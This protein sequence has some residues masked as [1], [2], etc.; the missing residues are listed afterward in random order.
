[1]K[2]ILSA[3]FISLGMSMLGQFTAT[4][5]N[6]VK[7]T[8]RIFKVYSNL[9]QYRYE[10]DES[11]MKGIVIA[12]PQENSMWLLMPDEKYIYKTTSDDFRMV[13]N[14]PVAGI[15]MY[16]A[17][18]EVKKT[19]NEKVSGYDC[20]ITEY[21]QGDTKV[22]T[23]WHAPDLNFIIK[24]TNHMAED[25]YM[26]LTDI[27]KWEVDPSMFIQPEDY[28]EVDDR[29]RPI[30]PEPEPPAAWTPVTL[31]LPINKTF[32]RGTKLHF[33]VNYDKYTR[34]K[35]SNDS[36]TPAK[37]IRYQSVKGKSLPDEEIAPL[38]YRTN[39]LFPGESKTLT[40][41]LKNGQEFTIEFHEG[42][43]KI[44]A[45]PE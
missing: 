4:M 5:T 6:T 32:E 12:S 8:A 41:D 27:R 44:E 20:E 9:D 28:T 16:A 19:G 3:L 29:M 43:M 30:V 18:G 17:Y 22:Y 26:E 25:S 24:A 21:Y 36:D 7:E 35:L 14:D 42:K 15:K 37:V 31:E 1:M 40:L 34:I 10:F 45:G 39:R 33:V 11:G 23:A 2:T 13:S 38:R